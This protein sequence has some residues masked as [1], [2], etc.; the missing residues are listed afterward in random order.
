[1]KLGVVADTHLNKWSKGL[2]LQL[3]HG[4]SGVDHILHAGDL[5]TNE[6]VA[7]LNVLAPVEAI[8]GNN[9]PWPLFQTLGRKKVLE[10]DGVKIGLIHGDCDGKMTLECAKSAF[11]TER[12]ECIVFGHSHNPYCQMHDGIL[13][14]NPGSPTRKRSNRQFSFGTLLIKDGLI[15]PE[16]HYFD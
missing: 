3:V 14:F 12:V 6:V 5:V 4:L 15:F 8:A 9:D 11:T 10:F 7:W 2:P 13:L 1:M 16:L